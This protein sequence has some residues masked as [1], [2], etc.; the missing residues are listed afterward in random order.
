MSNPMF[1]GLKHGQAISLDTGNFYICLN[2]M[3]YQIGD[4]R[5]KVDGTYNRLTVDSIDNI[6][7][8][9]FGKKTFAGFRDANGTEV[10][11]EPYNAAMDMKNSFPMVNG[12]T[13]YPDL[14][15]EMRIRRVLEQ[16]APYEQVWNPPEE[17][18]HKITFEVVGVWEDTGS[19]FIESS[20]SVGKTGYHGNGPYMLKTNKVAQD[21]IAQLAKTYP[22]ISFTP[23]SIE[24]TK[25]QDG[26]L[27]TERNLQFFS[28]N[29]YQVFK[30]LDEAK[31]REAEIRA[32]INRVAMMKIKPEEAT[33]ML[34]ELNILQILSSIRSNLDA[35]ESKTK[36]QNQL[37]AVKK[38]VRD[39]ITKIMSYN[40]E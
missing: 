40:K 1:D 8:V 13:Q 21:T 23:S 12:S 20:F 10:D 27:F 35:I 25:C 19:E 29:A 16:Y 34:T 6:Y 30:T 3:H 28:T 7:R 33:R 26:Y 5:V 31:Q 9:D 37:D 24:F 38:T 36:T 18:L 14:E 32:Y 4:N 15:T 22:A 11:I 17:T 39:T 2:Q